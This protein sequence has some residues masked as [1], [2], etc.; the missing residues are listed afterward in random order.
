MRVIAQMFRWLGNGSR[1]RR[2]ARRPLTLLPL[3]A[4]LAF[5]PA[6]PAL[7]DHNRMYV[8]CPASIQEGLQAFMQVRDPG[9]SSV[10]VSVV[11][12]HSDHT[13]DRGDFVPYD[14]QTLTSN[15]GDDTVRVP[16]TTLEDTLPEYNETF[17]IGFLADGH[18]H[19]CVVRILDDDTP[20]VTGVE[21]TSTPA[22]GSAYL[23][24]ESINVA[25][26][27]DQEVEVDGNPVQALY[28]GEGH[29]WRAADYYGGSGTKT[30]T[31]RYRIQ[32]IDRD[33][34]GVT[35]SSAAVDADRNPRHGFSGRIYAEGTDV[36]V[37]YTHSGLRNVPAHQVDGRPRIIDARIIST[38]PGGWESYRVNQVVEASVRFNAEVEVE[39]EIS[40]EMYVGFTGENWEEARR[41]AP[42][43]RGSGSDAL[44]FGYTVKPGDM[45]QRGIMIGSRYPGSIFHGVGKIT[46]KATDVEPAPFFS[47]TWHLEGQK[48][49]TAPPT[50]SSISFETRPGDDTAYNVGEGIRIQVTFSEEI[51]TTGSLLVELDVGG[52]TRQ[53]TFQ[54]SSTRSRSFSDTIAFSYRVREGDCDVDGVGISA[55]SIR[56]N[57]GAA[58]DRAGN[59]AGLSHDTVVADPAQR[60]AACRDG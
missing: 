2:G 57:G 58:Q 33:T 51:T 3:V 1:G 20:E 42:Y 16:I 12:N 24:G 48:V 22:A 26:T 29:A 52:V 56:L 44:V 23:A 41:F 9:A 19:G 36:L 18:W 49:D 54:S 60:V 45:D 5:I 34:D 8:I 21:I 27:F 59:A 43:L 6:H 15:S 35:V 50:I 46:G 7:G 4:A 31:F 10:A 47:G 53:A 14:G 11:T 17:S 32:T 38:P 28:V 55:N 40:L 39:G 37:D 30:L 25:V 13:A